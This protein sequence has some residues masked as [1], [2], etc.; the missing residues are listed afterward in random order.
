[1]AR[2]GAWWLGDS[3]IACPP[4]AGRQGA[5]PKAVINRKVCGQ[6]SIC[7]VDRPDLKE[8]S[9]NAGAL[10]TQSVPPRGRPA[11]TLHPRQRLALERADSADV[12]QRP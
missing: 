7:D 2:S 9:L 12:P 6:R 8:V 10:C 11:L 4:W 5:H 3:E 1:M